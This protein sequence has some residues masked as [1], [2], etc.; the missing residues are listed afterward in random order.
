M[1]GSPL[2]TVVLATYN[3]STVLP[4][5]IGSAL[6]QTFRDFELLVIGDGCT[7]DSEAVVASIQDPRVR[8][9]NL[10][11]NSGHQSAPNNEG[12]KHA[13]GHFVAYLGHDDLWLPHHLSC[14]VRALSDSVDLAYSMTELIGPDGDS[15]IAPCPFEYTS[16]MAIPPSCVMHRRSVVDA[17]GG[18]KDYRTLTCYPEVDLWRRIYDVRQTCV[19]VPRLSVIKFPAS[20]RRNAYQTRSSHEQA[21]WSRRIREEPDLEVMELA[22]HLQIEKGTVR[23]ISLKPYKYVLR[24]FVNDTSRRIRRRFAMPSKKSQVEAIRRFKGLE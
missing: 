8:W 13:R 10:P 11:S 17:V 2:V 5:S 4:Y 15:E 16:G 22:K 24:E 21:A 19:F 18:W 6:A 9:I 7:D 23:M 3:W 12:L 1:T 20:W 14:L